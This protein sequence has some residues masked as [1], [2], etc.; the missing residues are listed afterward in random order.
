MFVN[1]MD[2][3]NIGYV[4]PDPASFGKFQCAY[5]KG[6]HLQQYSY[7][8]KCGFNS[9]AE[10]I[11]W[12]FERYP[13]GNILD[14]ANFLGIQAQLLGLKLPHPQAQTFDPLAMEIKQRPTIA[15]RDKSGKLMSD[16]E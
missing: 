5:C 2:L 15:K 3:V 13:N 6:G 9:A 12:Y 10:A 1:G 4:S 11:R 14:Q 7:H 8:I 16:F